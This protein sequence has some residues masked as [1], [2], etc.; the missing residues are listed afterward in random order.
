MYPLTHPP[1]HQ[2][3]LAPAEQPVSL[4]IPKEDEAKAPGAVQRLPF[5]KLEG[6]EVKRCSECPPGSVVSEE[7]SG[8]SKPGQALAIHK[9]PAQVP[10]LQPICYH[11]ACCPLVALTLT[12]KRKKPATKPVEPRA[13]WGKLALGNPRPPLPHL[14]PK[15]G[16][17]SGSSIWMQ[18]S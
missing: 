7:G 5:P 6:K 8:V 14:S 15:E 13:A 18:N 16:I 2:G 9:P 10:K 4:H 11:G 12:C 3:V 17:V 1:T